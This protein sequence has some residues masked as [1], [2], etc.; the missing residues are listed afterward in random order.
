VSK[1]EVD[2]WL[3][4]R[5]RSRHENAVENVLLQKCITAYL[6]K[7]KVVRSTNGRKRVTEMPLF[8]GYVFVRPRI[9][10]YEGMR[11]IRGSCG[12]VLADSRPARLPETELQAVKTL[13]DS[14]VPLTVDQMLVSGKRVKITAGPFA[15]VEG[16]LV[17]MKDREVLSINVD[18]VG[19][20][21]RVEVDRDLVVPL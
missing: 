1:S 10:Q 14:G 2:P 9:D 17:L 5:T 18:M 4:L 11:Y 19:S 12:L 21:V 6:P 20:S 15:G 13:V 3:V 8:P 7:Y 16:E